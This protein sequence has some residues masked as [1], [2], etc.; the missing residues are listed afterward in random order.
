MRIEKTDHT[1]FRA[2]FVNRAKIMK[3]VNGTYKNEYASFVRIDPFNQNDI[4]ALKDNA[5]CWVSDRYAFAL[6]IY[7]AACAV[8]NKSKY[9]KDHAVYALTLQKE[10]YNELDSDK[11]LGLLQTSP[12][13][14]N[15]LLIEHIQVNPEYLYKSDAKY[16]TLGTAILNSIKNLSNKISCYPSSEKSVKDFYIK[17][18]FEK[19]PNS[20]NYYVW[21]GVNIF[22]G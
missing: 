4:S 8:R 22:R 20:L 15:S 19:E 21:R 17:N 3:F 12:Y 1:S 7:Y 14:D 9:Y 6:N 11:I 16:K 2:N 5:R 13:I 10:N 18:G